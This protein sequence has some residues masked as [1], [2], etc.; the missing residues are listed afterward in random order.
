MTRDEIRK[1]IRAVLDRKG[2]SVTDLSR[3]SKVSQRAIRGFLD[4]GEEVSPQVLYR[5][6][7]SV[8]LDN[9]S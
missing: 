4:G 8:A 1:E 3:Q 7:K 9:R 5:L 6:C 2:W